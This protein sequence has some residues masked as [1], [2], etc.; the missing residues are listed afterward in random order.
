MKRP[1]GQVWSR[2]FG[3]RIPSRWQDALCQQFQLQKRYNDPQRGICQS[4]CTIGY[5]LITSELP[6]KFYFKNWSALSRTRK[7]WRKTITYGHD[8][9][10]SAVKSSRLCWV[11]II[12]PL[13]LQKS[14]HS[15]MS[16]SARTQ[17]DYVHSTTLYRDMRVFLLLWVY[18]LL[19]I[20]LT[21]I[22]NL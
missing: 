2:V 19:A 10:A 11:R 9:I 8:R 5:E 1:Q 12:S 3:V 21:W 22:K 20:L 7:F 13:P 6:I 15:L 4:M 16:I 17:R 18:V 14:A